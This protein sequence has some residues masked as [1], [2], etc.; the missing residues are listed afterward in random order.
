MADAAVRAHWIARRYGAG[1]VLE[2]PILVAPF[3]R[4]P[5][6]AVE[7]HTRLIGWLIADRPEPFPVIVG[8]SDRIAE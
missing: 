4:S 6:V 3:S 1:D 5:I 8:L 7:G 2:P